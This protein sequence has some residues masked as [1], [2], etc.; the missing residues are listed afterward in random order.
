MPYNYKIFVIVIIIYY[1]AGMNTTQ[2]NTA[3][4]IKD[5]S[6]QESLVDNIVLLQLNS[7]EAVVNHMMQ[8]LYTHKDWQNYHVNLDG[9][10]LMY[11]DDGGTFIW[12]WGK[13]G[14]QIYSCIRYGEEYSYQ[15]NN[16][17]V[18]INT[19]RINISAR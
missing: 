12:D 19:N 4:G 1:V 10:F 7:I 6:E 14:K 18:T 11:I 5:A 15:L 17:R 8:T 2:H 3:T 13:R 16:L 9:K